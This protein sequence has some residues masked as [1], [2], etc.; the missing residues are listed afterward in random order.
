MKN[1]DELSRM[2][3]KQIRND[4]TKKGAFVLSAVLCLIISVIVIVIVAVLIIKDRNYQK[5]IEKKWESE[6]QMLEVKLLQGN[7]KLKIKYKGYEV[8]DEI[9]NLNFEIKNLGDNLG[10]DILVGGSINAIPMETYS[11]NQRISIPD[12]AFVPLTIQLKPAY[13]NS[14]GINKIDNFE[15]YIKRIGDSMQYSMPVKLEAMN[16]DL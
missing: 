1:F 8:V 11:K 10:L 9:I 2:E 14:I 16:I 12:G 4:K 5:E 6:G 7:N 13:L 3:N 15:F